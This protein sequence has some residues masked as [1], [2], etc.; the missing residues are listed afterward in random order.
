MGAGRRL[1]SSALAMP[2][3]GGAARTVTLVVLVGIIT[4]YVPNRE[5]AISVSATTEQMNV[6]V[7]ANDLVWDLLEIGM[8]YPAA[9]LATPA[10]GVLGAAP[11]PPA[12]APAQPTLVPDP[13][14]PT[15]DRAPRAASGLSFAVLRWAE[16]YRLSLRGFEIDYVEIE[17]AFDEGAAPLTVEYEA[18][19]GELKEALVLNGT[20]L[21]IPYQTR[22]ERTILPLRGY[23]TIGGPPSTTNTHILRAGSYE[24]R[25]TLRPG[26]TPVVAKAAFFSGRPGQFRS[27]GCPMV[28]A[29]VRRQLCARDQPGACVARVPH[30]A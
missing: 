1:L 28:G 11:Q 18:E 3:T 5:Q 10:A 9:P 12:A 29:Y 20:T 27:G 19:T 26:H 7:T 15:C 25:Q 23:V 16:G 13:A 14:I 17:V 8:C 24:S 21:R 22:G 4:Y 2:Q 30:A 6:Q